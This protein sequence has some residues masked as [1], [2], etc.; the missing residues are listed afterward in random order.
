MGHLNPVTKVTTACKSNAIELMS[1]FSPRKLWGTVQ[2]WRVGK[3]IILQFD[4][5]LRV[6]SEICG[7]CF[8]IPPTGRCRRFRALLSARAVVT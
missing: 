8:A 1:T 3:R 6:K 4:V 5:P 2:S 7:R